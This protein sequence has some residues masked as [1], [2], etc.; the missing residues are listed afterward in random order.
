MIGV[1]VE[2]RDAEMLWMYAAGFTLVV[3]WH[4]PYI[5]T[6]RESG[7]YVLYHSLR[8]RPVPP[9]DRLIEHIPGV[10]LLDHPSQRLDQR[11]A[12]VPVRHDGGAPF[13]FR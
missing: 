8:N 3:D 5:N 11:A 6:T 12:I 7:L 13:P 9:R 1:I 2:R 10:F 4:L